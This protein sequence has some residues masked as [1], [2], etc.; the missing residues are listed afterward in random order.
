MEISFCRR[1]ELF[2]FRRQS[3]NRGAAS[4]L[5]VNRSRHNLHCIFLAEYHTACANGHSLVHL[6]VN[7][8]T[9]GSLSPSGMERRSAGRGSTVGD[10]KG[11]ERI[12]CGGVRGGGGGGGEHWHGERTRTESR[13]RP[14][15]A[16]RWIEGTEGQMNMQSG[17]R[18]LFLLPS[19]S[20]NH[21]QML[22][23]GRAGGRT[24][25]TESR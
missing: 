2:L 7:F 11:E 13:E 5:A 1:E 4:V 22:R 14:R 3:I 18:V 19:D 10:R 16:A 25:E 23:E 9:E 15:R 17:P 24:G 12:N 8:T 21:P 20:T 6:K